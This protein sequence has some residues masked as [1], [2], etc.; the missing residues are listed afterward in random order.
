MWLLAYVCVACLDAW[1]G[2]LDVQCDYFVRTARAKRFSSLPPV[3]AALMLT[4]P[5]GGS[6]LQRVWVHCTGSTDRGHIGITLSVY[7]QCNVYNTVT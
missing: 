3:V 2:A 1:P 6:S 7:A 4:C 5:G